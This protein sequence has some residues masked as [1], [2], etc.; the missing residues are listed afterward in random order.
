M[1]AF[2]QCTLK[3]KGP[4]CLRAQRGSFLICCV[5]TDWAPLPLHPAGALGLQHVWQAETGGLSGIS[6][7]MERKPAPA[8]RASGMRAS[9]VLCFSQ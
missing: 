7:H 3:L 1:L 2:L 4:C 8:Q 5:W 9:L 6:S